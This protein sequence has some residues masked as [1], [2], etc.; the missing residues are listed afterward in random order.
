MRTTIDAAGRLVIPRVIREQ[1]GVYGT[2][3]VDVEIDGSGIRIEP[4]TVGAFG[5]EEG[6]LVIPSIGI[7]LTAEMVDRLRD[8]DRR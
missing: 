2:T 1:V 8:A 7:Q 6:R 3:E 4:V 5:E